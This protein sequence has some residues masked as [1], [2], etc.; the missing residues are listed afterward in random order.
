V[1]QSE[2]QYG[3][4]VKLLR[5][6]KHDFLNH[7]Q[8]ISGLLQLQKPEQALNYVRKI[9]DDIQQG[10]KMLEISLPELAIFLLEKQ[11]EAANMQLTIKIL[12]TTELAAVG[13]PVA[14]LMHTIALLWETVIEALKFVPAMARELSL[15]ITEEEY[16]YVFSFR[17]PAPPLAEER[18]WKKV[19]R[20][21][22]A[23]MASSGVV[24]HEQAIEK[25]YC[26]LFEISKKPAPT[27]GDEG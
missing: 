26:I 5:H 23:R 20:E 15:F 27:A 16:R 1:T 21:A 3:N 14:R 10:S 2:K 8:V 9:T 12:A 19:Y 11:R 4:F 13:I 25:D 24:L 17:V 22:A 6:Q 7:L 18:L